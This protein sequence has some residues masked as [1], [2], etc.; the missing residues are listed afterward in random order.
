M[1]F[2]L[3]QNVDAAVRSMLIHRG[4]E[5]WS[6]DQAN[7]GQDVDDELTVYAHEHG[8]V[9]L[10]H[11]QEFS[12]RRRKNVIGRHIWLECNEFDAAE[13]LNGYFEDV[14]PLLER[15]EH[16]WV[17]ITRETVS[18]GHGWS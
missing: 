4:H 15:R 13:I 12:Q 16:L 10:T 7:L 8:A 14:F 6:T 11:D 9:L 3:D 5:A 18:F 1:R 17:R 2:F